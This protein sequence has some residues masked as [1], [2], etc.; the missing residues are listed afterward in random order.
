MALTN[1][2]HNMIGGIVGERLKPVLDFGIILSNYDLK[3]NSYACPIPVTDY[4]V[5][6]Q[7]LYD[8]SVELTETYVDGKHE[9]PG[10]PRSGEHKH[11]VELPKK[12]AKLKPGQ[13]VLVAIVANEFIVVDIVFDAMHLIEGEPEW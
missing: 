1:T 4:S 6:R 11:K 10:I 7:L 2:L 12:L 5:C 3:I 13:K 9:H 8:P